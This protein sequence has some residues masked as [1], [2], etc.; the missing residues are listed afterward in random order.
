MKKLKIVP[1]FKSEQAEAAF[2]S[3]HDSAEYINWSKAKRTI[4]P[5]LKPTSRPVPIRF[6]ISLLARLK[7]LANKRHIPY[8][9][10]LKMLLEKSVERE[11]RSAGPGK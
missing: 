7:Y 10:L 6:P 1:K 4:F 8:Q 5:D 2:W 3:A 11:L 9:S